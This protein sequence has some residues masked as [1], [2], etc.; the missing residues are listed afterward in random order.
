MR[1][2]RLSF[3]PSKEHRAAIGLAAIKENRNYN[4]IF[5]D[6]ISKRL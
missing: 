1:G 5:K 6:A 2:P 4:K 3:S